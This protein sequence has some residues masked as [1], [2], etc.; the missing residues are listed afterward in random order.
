MSPLFTA[1]EVGHSVSA[2][3]LLDAEPPAD[4][5]IGF[6]LLGLSVRT[7]YQWALSKGHKETAKEIASR[8]QS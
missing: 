6:S 5:A 4:M 8:K 3:K 1:A 7:P 2:A